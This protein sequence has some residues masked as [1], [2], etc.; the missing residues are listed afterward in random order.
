MRRPLQFG[1][2]S[3]CEAKATAEVAP[4][5]PN[6]PIVTQCKDKDTACSASSS[7]LCER[8]PRLDAAGKARVEECRAMDCPA[9]KSCLHDTAG[10]A[11]R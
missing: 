1:P 5:S 9:F 11:G 3:D 8:L 4:G 7:Y 2:F 6:L 10:A